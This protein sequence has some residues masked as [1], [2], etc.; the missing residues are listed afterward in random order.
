MKHHDSKGK[1]SKKIAASDQEKPLPST[2]P[3]FNDNSASSQCA[4]LLEALKQGPI[5]TYDAMRKL[6]CY[7][8]PA[9]IIT[10]RKRGHNITTVKKQI[11]TEAGTWHWVGLYVLTAAKE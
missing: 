3:K 5:T 9:R 6:D 4:R 7:H 8:P 11:Q 10:L 1:R 2:K